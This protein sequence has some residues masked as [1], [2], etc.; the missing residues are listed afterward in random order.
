MIQKCHFRILSHPYTLQSIQL[1]SWCDFLEV[2]L[3]IVKW[4][5]LSTQFSE[6]PLR[7]IYED[8]A[9]LAVADLPTL[10]PYF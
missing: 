7:N 8:V 2:E 3:L 9:L 6:H 1:F 10:L 4:S 5:N